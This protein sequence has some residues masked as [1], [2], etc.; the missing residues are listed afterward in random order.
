MALPVL[1]AAQVEVVQLAFPLDCRPGATCVVQNYVDHDPGPG[2]RDYACGFLTYDGHKGTDIRLPDTGVMRQ[3]VAVLAA[4]PGRVRALRD[5]MEDVNV[6]AIGAAAVAGREAGNSV[7]VDLGGGWEVQYAHL[8][9]GSVAVKIGERVRTGQT[10]GL[11][12]LSGNTAFPHLHFEV[13]FEGKTVDPF[14]GLRSAEKCR[15]G[16]RPLWMPETLAALA[17]APTGVLGAGFAGAPPK[18]EDGGV[19]AGTLTPLAPDAPEFVFW[20][21]LY[22]VRANDFEELTLTGPDGQVVAEHRVSIPGNR[23][24]W[25]LSARMRRSGA[26]WPPGIYRAEYALYRGPDKTRVAAMM[27]EYK[28]ETREKD[29]A[30]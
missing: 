12:G 26:N 14:V 24:T 13:R 3:G 2:A 20:I 30:H 29:G 4:A 27:R 11:I 8:R 28:I 17:Y 7:V 15:P 6:R 21:H 9:K 22:G 16:E 23:A 19:D 25:L 1:C 5:G 10:I 18:L